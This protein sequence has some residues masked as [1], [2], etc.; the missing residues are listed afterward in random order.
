MATYTQD[1]LVAIIGAYHQVGA[2]LNKLSIAISE[3][4]PDEYT[5]EG[6]EFITDMAFCHK[7]MRETHVIYESDVIEAESVI[8][9]DEE[10][11]TQE[12]FCDCRAGGGD[13]AA[14]GKD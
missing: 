2:Q 4:E 3:A 5:K 8:A 10:D 11:D 14:E 7:R 6:R 13:Q 1:K 12:P 9:T